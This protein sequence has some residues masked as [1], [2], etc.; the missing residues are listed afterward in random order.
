MKIRHFCLCCA[1][2]AVS[3]L[4]SMLLFIF[5]ATGSKFNDLFVCKLGANFNVF[6]FAEL[7]V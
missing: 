7:T 4:V 2:P 5:K 3:N 6:D 1:I